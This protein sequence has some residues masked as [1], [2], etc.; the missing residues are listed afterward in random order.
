MAQTRA[1]KFAGNF[2]NRLIFDSKPEF[3]IVAATLL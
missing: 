2:K 3:R 1:A